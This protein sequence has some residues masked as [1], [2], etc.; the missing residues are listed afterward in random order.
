M[1]DRLR[2]LKRPPRGPPKG[3]RCVSCLR[4]ATAYTWVY[5]HDEKMGWGPLKTVPERRAACWVHE[6]DNTYNL[7]PWR[8]SNLQCL[9]R[10][11]RT[12]VIDL[13]LEREFPDDIVWLPLIGTL[14]DIPKDRPTRA[15]LV[16]SLPRCPWCGHRLKRIGDE[17]R[18]RLP[19]A[20]KVTRR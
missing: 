11:Q 13:R 10:R 16:N 9:H 15:S 12:A 1:T 5:R 17:R 7:E 3:T 19:L 4:P 18:W 6:L 20:R 8:C 2:G 14:D